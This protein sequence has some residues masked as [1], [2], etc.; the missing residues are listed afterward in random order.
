MYD[1]ISDILLL[2]YQDLIGVKRNP[3]MPD[4]RPYLDWDLCSLGM[5]YLLNRHRHVQ[6]LIG[7]GKGG[8][9]AF[10]VHRQ[11][12]AV[13][14]VERIED[15]FP[16]RGDEN[17]SLRRTMQRSTAAIDFGKEQSYRSS[18]QFHAAPPIFFGN[19]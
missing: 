9:Q 15:R 13:V 14:R 4:R 12:D 8:P 7:R 18:R 2:L 3:E 17:M 11:E 10:I 5:K 19:T 6:G 16:Q 1:G